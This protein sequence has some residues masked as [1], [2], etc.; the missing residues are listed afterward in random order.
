MIL[1][2]EQRNL[3]S[4][5]LPLIMWQFRIGCDKCNAVLGVTIQTREETQAFAYAAG[6]RVNSRARKYFH[7]CK[8][9]ANK[10]RP[11]GS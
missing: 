11:S 2:D 5:Y 4:E 6:W 8:S 1:K 7:L 10:G 3:G 9:C